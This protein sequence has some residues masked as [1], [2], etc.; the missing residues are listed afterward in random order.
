MAKA[1]AIAV[2]LYSVRDAL[3][4]SVPADQAQPVRVLAAELHGDVERLLPVRN[5]CSLAPDR[6]ELACTFNVSTSG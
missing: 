1:A 2:Q 4:N 3:A 5:R 6:C